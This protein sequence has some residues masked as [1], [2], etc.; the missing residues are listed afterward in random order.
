MI[1]LVDFETT[2]LDPKRDALV[3]A[4]WVHCDIEQ[5]VAVPTWSLLDPGRHIPPESSAVHHITDGDVMAAVNEGQ[6]ISRQELIE[7]LQEHDVLVA[8]NA[9]FDSAFVPEVQADWI[10]TWKLAVRLWPKA[11]NYKLQTL[12]YYLG[13]R[14]SWP[15]AIA[16]LHPHRAAY[17]VAFLLSLLH[18]CCDELGVGGEDAVRKMVEISEAPALL[19]RFTFGKHAGQPVEEIPKSYLR[20][21][22]QNHDDPNV[23][24]TAEVALGQN[25]A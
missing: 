24:Y 1:T 20:W 22:V 8:H 12:R 2:G 5:D 6:A 18:A 11:P 4:A 21:L 7:E 25:D 13:L 19:P 3:E 16:M 14:P 10:C 15:D 17:D 9:Q 23:I